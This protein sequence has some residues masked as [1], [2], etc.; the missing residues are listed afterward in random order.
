MCVIPLISLSE[1]HCY[2]GNQLNHFRSPGGK[3][4]LLWCEHARMSNRGRNTLRAQCDH[5]TDKSLLARWYTPL[6]SVFGSLRQQDP[7]FEARLGCVVRCHLG[8]SN[9]ECRLEIKNLI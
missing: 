9:R 2:P 3:D 4:H 1:W 7:E 6:R 5:T 8:K